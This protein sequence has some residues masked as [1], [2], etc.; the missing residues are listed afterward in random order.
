MKSIIDKLK[1]LA[2]ISILGITVG[3]S[4]CNDQPKQQH[5]EVAID[6]I[7]GQDELI[8]DTDASV[9]YGKAGPAPTVAPD[10]DTLIYIDKGVKPDE[11]FE[12]EEKNK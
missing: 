2:G 9:S 3:I 11:I 12:E 6:T 1:Q 10:L 7:P 4:S 8:I 5:G